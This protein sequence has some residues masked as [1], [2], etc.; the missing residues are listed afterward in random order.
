MD[1]GIGS[2][3]AVRCGIYSGRSWLEFE[4]LVEELVDLGDDPVLHHEIVGGAELG[5]ELKKLLVDVL[6]GHGL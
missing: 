3:D 1:A 5:V 6:D 4:A 2:E